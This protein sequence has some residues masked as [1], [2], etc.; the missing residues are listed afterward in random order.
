MK[1]YGSY[2]VPLIS[3]YFNADWAKDLKIPFFETS[4]FHIQGRRIDIKFWSM[5]RNNHVTDF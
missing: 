2:F 3:L 5:L 4:L 1:T